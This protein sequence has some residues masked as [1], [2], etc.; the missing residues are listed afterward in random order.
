MATFLKGIQPNE[1][2]A[3][4]LLLTRHFSLAFLNCFLRVT[5]SSAIACMVWLCKLHSFDVPF[6]Y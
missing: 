3:D 5:N 1:R 6:V 2:L 4:L